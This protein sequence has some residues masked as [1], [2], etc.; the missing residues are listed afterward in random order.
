LRADVEAPSCFETGVAVIAADGR[1]N[2]VVEA[3][4]TIAGSGKISWR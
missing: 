3:I 2:A 4:G 1:D